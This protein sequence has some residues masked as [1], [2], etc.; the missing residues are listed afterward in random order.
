M[1]RKFGIFAADLEL[2][3]CETSGSTGAKADMRWARS[4]VA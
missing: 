3:F 2:F 4:E 1:S